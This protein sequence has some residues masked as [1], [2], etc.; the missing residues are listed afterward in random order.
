M[1]TPTIFQWYGILR[2]NYQFTM[3]QAV[4]FALWLTR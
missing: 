2:H 4:R 1:K 3:F